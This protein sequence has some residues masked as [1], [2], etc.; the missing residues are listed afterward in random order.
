MTFTLLTRSEL[1]SVS[2]YLGGRPAALA[3]ADG[4]RV[5]APRILSGVDV[6]PKGQY[7]ITYADGSSEG[8][9]AGML[10]AVGGNA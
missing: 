7:V 1:F 8:L 5:S 2:D 6:D 4:T 10:L 3:T 9:A